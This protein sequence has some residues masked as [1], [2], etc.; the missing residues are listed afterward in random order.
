VRWWESD[1]GVTRRS[2]QSVITKRNKTRKYNFQLLFYFSVFLHLQ[3]DLQDT[4]YANCYC[5]Y[6]FKL[7]CGSDLLHAGLAPLD[8]TLLP[9]RTMIDCSSGWTERTANWS[10]ELRL[11]PDDLSLC[12]Q[13]TGLS[14]ADGSASWLPRPQVSCHLAGEVFH[15]VVRLEPGCSP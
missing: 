12:S 8:S 7:R 3:T 6:D 13:H 9:L 2:Q 15:L 5:Y 14:M 10:D 4:D 11:E 1:Q